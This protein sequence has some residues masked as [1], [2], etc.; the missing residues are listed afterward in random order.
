MVT[1]LAILGVLA[2]SIG[3]AIV[4]ATRALPDANGGSGAVDA[5]FVADQI[6]TE[7]HSAVSVSRYS[8]TL[9]EFGVERSGVGHTIAYEW[10]GRP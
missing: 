3:S 8:P 7:L 10:S 4:I 1:A 2:V 5:A 6:A 9:I